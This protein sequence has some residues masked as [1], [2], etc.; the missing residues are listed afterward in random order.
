MGTT[1]GC[2]QVSAA[3]MA[4]KSTVSPTHPESH[5]VRVAGAN[6]GGQSGPRVIYNQ[7]PTKYIRIT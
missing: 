5:I 3:S 4:V 2:F 1:G 6:N 7:I